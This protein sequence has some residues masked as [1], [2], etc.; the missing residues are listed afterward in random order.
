MHYRAEKDP[1]TQLRDSDLLVRRHHLI[2]E[3]AMPQESRMQKR[4]LPQSPISCEHKQP[5]QKRPKAR[6]KALLQLFCQQWHCAITACH[7]A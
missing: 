3:S 7:S 6:E 1:E 5:I 4:L 2:S